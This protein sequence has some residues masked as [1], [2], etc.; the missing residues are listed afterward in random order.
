MHDFIVQVL[1]GIVV[2]SVLAALGWIGKRELSFLRRMLGG[3]RIL[4]KSL[5]V[6]NTKQLP[7]HRYV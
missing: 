6:T 3:S 2:N 4:K 1:V 7:I 5:D